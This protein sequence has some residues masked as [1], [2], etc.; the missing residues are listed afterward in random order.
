MPEIPSKRIK[1]LTLYWTTTDGES[2]RV[3]LGDVVEVLRKMP[4]AS[5]HCVVTSPPYWSLRDYGTGEWVGGKEG[6]DHVERYAESA[7]KS[8]TLGPSAAARAKGDYSK[9]LPASNAAFKATARQFA[10]RC[11]KC[12]SKRTD[13]QLGSEKAHDCSGWARGENCASVDWESGCH[14]CRMRV[15][16]GDVYRVLRDDGTLFL[17]YGDTYLDG[18]MACVP[19]RVALGLQADG[20]ILRS[21]IPWIKRS[22]M[23]ESC[24]NRPAKSLEYVFMLAKKTGYYYDADAVRKPGKGGWSSDGFLPDSAKDKANNGK[25]TAATGASRSNR[26]SEVVE[27]GAGR[28]F[29]NADL[30]FESVNAPHGL[31]GVGDELVGLDVTSQSYGGA[32]FATFGP[33]LIRPLILAG[34][35]ERGCC[36]ECGA[37]WRRMVGVRNVDASR[38]D[39]QRKLSG[40]EYNEQASTKTLGWEPT[41]E[42]GG[43][44]A[45]CTVFDPFLGSGTS[46]CVAL[47]HGR[48]G[49]GIELSEKYV[50]KNAIPRIEGVLLAVPALSHLRPRKA[51]VVK[52]GEEI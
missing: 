46:I 19:W 30:W 18:N 33:R 22:S 3:Y 49:V 27:E 10:G 21:D 9:I 20:W 1:P 35:S 13:N 16:F 24:T 44:V 7:A 6:C 28:N 26:S 11:G 38:G 29:R 50:V 34:T 47:E 40:K 25:Q 51:R 41:C 52:G 12:G 8:S 36:G 15:V 5:V 45:P 43:E 37:P 48:R 39:K 32:H 23:P 4:A 14:V 2:A 42:C 17:N 31:T